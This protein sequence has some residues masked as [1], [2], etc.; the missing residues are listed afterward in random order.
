MSMNQDEKQMIMKWKHTHCHKCG[1][2][3]RYGGDEF[4]ETANSTGEKHCWCVDCRGGTSEHIIHAW[5]VHREDPA[6]TPAPPAGW[7]CPVC[8]RGLSPW[9]GVCPCMPW[10]GS[11]I[12][13]GQAG[14]KIFR[15]GKGWLTDEEAEQLTGEAVHDKDGIKPGMVYQK[16]TDGTYGFDWVR[17]N[18]EAP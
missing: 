16:K 17:A 18:T 10:I 15:P 2:T 12:P 4:W 11:I 5:E 3:L 14:G 13:A 9:M 7:V 8:G 1:K 6:P